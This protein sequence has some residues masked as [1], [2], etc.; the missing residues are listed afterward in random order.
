[1][2]EPIEESIANVLMFMGIKSIEKIEMSKQPRHATGTPA[3]LE[4]IIP[5]NGENSSYCKLV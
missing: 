2:L 1:M 3:Q 4:T 5:W